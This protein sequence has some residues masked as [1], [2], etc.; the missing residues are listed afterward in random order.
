MRKVVTDPVVG[1]VATRWL[2]GKIPMDL[3]ITEVTDGLVICGDWTFDRITGAEIDEYLGWGPP[4]LITGS[5]LT[6]KE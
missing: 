3:K 6:E 1:K 4:P 5:V 2:A